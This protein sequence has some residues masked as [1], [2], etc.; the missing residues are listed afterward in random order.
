M[1]GVYLGIHRGSSLSGVGG[2]TLHA[3]L[4]T[5]GLAGTSASASVVPA[6]VTPEA[7]RALTPDTPAASNGMRISVREVA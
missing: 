4:G 2:N 5:V 3:V 1:C 7:A 6:A